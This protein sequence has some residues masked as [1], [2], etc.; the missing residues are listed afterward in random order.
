ML[1]L[2]CKCSS[3]TQMYGHTVSLNMAVAS[4]GTENSC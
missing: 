1:Y 2:M 4:D 3:Q